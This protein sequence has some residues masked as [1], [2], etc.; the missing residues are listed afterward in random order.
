M[1]FINLTDAQIFD[2][3]I[4]I[5]SASPTAGSQLSRYSATAL[6]VSSGSKFVLIQIVPKLVF[7]SQFFCSIIC[8]FL[9]ASLKL[10]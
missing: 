5:E 4:K 1:L 8:L 6:N 3:L 9:V 2:P 7:L 10:S